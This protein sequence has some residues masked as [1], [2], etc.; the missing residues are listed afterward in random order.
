MGY[1][2]L[3]LV[4]VMKKET[5]FMLSR[6]KKTKPERISKQSSFYLFE[7][8]KIL[9]HIILIPSVLKSKNREDQKINFDEIRP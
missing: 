7:S 4:L 2:R 9:E 6:I 1:V 5:G 8:T 3:Q